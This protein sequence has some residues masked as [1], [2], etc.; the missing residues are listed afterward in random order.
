MPHKRRLTLLFVLL[1][2]GSIVY[3]S[4][5]LVAMTQL[6]RPL[7]ATTIL[8][9]F[10]GV[11]AIASLS[12]ICWVGS[13]PR[14]RRRTWL[15][16]RLTGALPE[17]APHHPLRRR[18]PSLTELVDNLTRASRDPRISG[19]LLRIDTLQCRWGKVDELRRRIAAVREAGKP[20]VAYLE[21][22]SLIEYLVATAADEIH[23]PPEGEIEL[24]GIRMRSPFL[25]GLLEKIGLEA[26]VERIGK[27]KSAGDIFTREQMSEA[28]REM[29]DS[30]LDDLQSVAA[31]W[32]AEGRGLTVERA[33]AIFDDPP[34]DAQALL[35][36]GLIDKLQ[37]EDQ[38]IDQLKQRSGQKKT[39]REIDGRQYARRAKR[40]R[41]PLILL[42]NAEG[43]I[44]HGPSRRSS[45]WG[46]T[47]GSE[48]LIALLQK[49][50]KQKKAK[51]LILRIDS[52]GGSGLA[53]ALV[54]REIR[55][56]AE[57]MPVI[58]SMSDVAGSGGYYL[59][60]AADSIVA[61]PGTITG[62]IGVVGAR[63]SGGPLLER[64]GL[65]FDGS[66]RGTFAE[67]TVFD[68]R[69]NPTEEARFRSKI[70]R[71]YDH[72]VSRAAECREQGVEQLEAVAQ[73]RVW[74]GE[75]ALTHQ[76]IDQLG[77]LETALEEARR[78]ARLPAGSPVRVWQ[79]GPPEN[80]LAAL[81]SLLSSPATIGGPLFRA[82]E[83]LALAPEL[84]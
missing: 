22:G 20:V 42:I 11:Y 17:Q 64:L 40:T 23:L 2:G 75:Q 58:A 53:S 4:L 66:S 76:L 12:L 3:V 47:A 46:R 44:V 9:L 79:L 69:L 68:R 16:L 67:S 50:R 31:R 61:Y 35:A 78:R 81:M 6:V 28:H 83:P 77:G 63:F 84:C 36:R 52:P 38:L 73:G 59:A 25:A 29:A 24:L 30:L 14:L 74:T 34:I 33:R 49:A 37:Y 15:R 51:A 19:V 70:R 26:E 54:W 27:Y 62:S 48:S 45:L 10:W 18:D 13:P 39:L 43:T 55:R 71:F 72:F 1:I 56:T 5:G 57:Q 41:G 32:I 60:M 21:G 80:Q 65:A 82:G 8:M 7:S